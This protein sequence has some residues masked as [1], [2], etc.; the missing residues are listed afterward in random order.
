MEEDERA[1]RELSGLL[2]EAPTPT[3]PDVPCMVHKLV[4]ARLPSYHEGVMTA[5][6]TFLSLPA[7][8]YEG[9]IPTTVQAVYTSRVHLL[10]AAQ[11]ISALDLSR[12]KQE[13]LFQTLTTPHPLPANARYIAFVDSQTL[14][15][16]GLPLL[17]QL[18]QTMEHSLIRDGIQLYNRIVT[19]KVASLT[20]IS[21][22]TEELR[23]VLEEEFMDAQI[24]L[25]H[26]KKRLSQCIDAVGG[27]IANMKAVEK[28]EVEC[29]VV[30]LT[31]SSHRP[32]ILEKVCTAAYLILSAENW[33][34]NPPWTEIHNTV[35]HRD[36]TAFSFAIFEKP[37]P[38]TH[39]YVSKNSD[40]LFELMNTISHGI[41]K[42]SGGDALE[43]LYLWCVSFATYLGQ[44]KIMIPLQDIIL[45]HDERVVEWRGYHECGKKT[46]ESLKCVVKEDD[47]EGE[48]GVV[49]EV[50]ELELVVPE[51]RLRR[52]RKRVVDTI[53][54]W[55]DYDVA[56]QV[57][58]ERMISR[59]FEDYDIEKS[60][61]LSVAELTSMYGS[62]ESFGVPVTDRLM[63]EFVAS[64]SRNG[65]V[66]RDAFSILMCK[67]VSR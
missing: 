9:L 28:A 36:G 52:A 1:R 8:M 47:A 12:G 44:M 60:G 34:D 54:G 11:S 18:L 14:A 48:S 61:S 50:A 15:H 7:S 58:S 6:G 56:A 51:E 43:G 25:S 5:I 10:R 4:H 66:S 41:V 13:Q 38:H 19:S 23:G 3:P 63:A 20:A 21:K 27:E 67:L 33:D 40:L 29:L 55:E 2:P 37:K 24:T 53:E 30:A 49:S 17:A 22:Q 42:S 59:L 62:L 32:K 64:H 57:L 46:L 16:I 45:S 65:Q 35:F 31:Q 39:K 26:E